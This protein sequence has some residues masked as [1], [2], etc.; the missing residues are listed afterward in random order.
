MATIGESVSCCCST[1]RHDAVH[2]IMHAQ[3]WRVLELLLLGV[4]R[5]KKVELDPL[6]LWQLNSSYIDHHGKNV[7]R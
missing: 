3:A 7:Q 1:A 4:H 2:H 5:V 6:G